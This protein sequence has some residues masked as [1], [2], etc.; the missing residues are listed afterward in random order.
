[1]TKWLR[2]KQNLESLLIMP[3]I[4]SF[5]ESDNFEFTMREAQSRNCPFCP[6]YHTIIHLFT[7][8]VQAI[9]NIFI[10]TNLT[11]FHKKVETGVDLHLIRIEELNVR[12]LTSYYKCVRIQYY[13]W[14]A[15]SDIPCKSKVVCTFSFNC[16]IMIENYSSQ[17][18]HISNLK[19]Y[20]KDRPGLCH[21]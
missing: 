11:D 17:K 3:N 2:A 16:K 4:I 19:D 10:V 7:E 9:K 1:M 21:V 18:R 12:A 8:C 6:A 13:Y 14:L 20:L 15:Y 5:I